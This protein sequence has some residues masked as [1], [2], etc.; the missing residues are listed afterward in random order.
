MPLSKIVVLR[1][2]ITQNVS[3]NPIDYT[4]GNL[5]YKFY[6]S[7]KRHWQ[8]ISPPWPEKVKFEFMPAVLAATTPYGY[9]FV[10]T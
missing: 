8:D 4:D 2:Q 10:L 3:V 6:V 7:V 5:G 1:P 9:V